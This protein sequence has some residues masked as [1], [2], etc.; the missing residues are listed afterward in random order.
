MPLWRRPPSSP[1]L[2]KAYQATGPFDAYLVR[3]WLQRNGV[4]AQVRGE[5][6]M[7]IRGDVPIGEAWP[8][9]WVAPEHL[10]MASGLIQEFDGPTLVHPPWKCTCQEEN[11][12]NFG[13]CWNCG[14]DRPGFS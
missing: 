4:K 5:A 8:T 14:R 9:L 1:S 11:A 2:V 3:D 7:S 13:S 10:K 6:L 12:P